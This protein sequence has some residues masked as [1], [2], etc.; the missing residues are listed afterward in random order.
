MSGHSKW[1]N[2]QAKKGKMDAKKGKIFTKIGKELAIASKNGGSNPDTNAKLRDVIAKAKANNMPQDTVT[3]A[4]K[5]GAGE[6]EGVNYEE[7]VYEGYGPSG[8]AV[9]VKT[10]TDNKNR[11]AGN[12]RAAFT[13][14]GGNMGSTGCVSFMFQTKGQIV[15]ERQD[16][17]DEDEIMMLALDAGAEDFDAQEE[18][19]EIT[20]TPEDFGTVR[21][22]LEGAGLEFLSAEVTMIPDTMS[23][24]DM[25]TAVKIQKLID[26]L[27]DD[28]DV[29][30]VYHNAEFPEGFEE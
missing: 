2:I 16:N 23:A 15:I 17:M 1:H 19:F 9:I 6:M 4:I 29:Q 26:K 22:A 3:R 30:D 14:Q 7:I 18:V 10:L 13:K 5:K 28:D 20:T 25:E 8:V 24:V 27:E 11:T 12:V 21:E